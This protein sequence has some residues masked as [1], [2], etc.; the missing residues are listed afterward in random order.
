MTEEIQRLFEQVK[1]ASCTIDH[2]HWPDSER[3]Y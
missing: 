2:D 1:S 3:P